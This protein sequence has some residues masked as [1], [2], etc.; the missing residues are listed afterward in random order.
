MLLD[1]P[2]DL[3]RQHAVLGQAQDEPTGAVPGAVNG[4]VKAQGVR[5]ADV[6]LFGPLMIYSAMDRKPPPWMNAAMLAIG[7]GTILYNAG[8][9]LKVQRRQQPSVD[10]L[11]MP[12]RAGYLNTKVPLPGTSPL[13]PRYVATLPRSRS[14]WG[15]K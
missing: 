15:R 13:R 4:E 12:P 11:A 9:Y 1:L 8:N 7:V 14:F 3:A 10:G 5:L 6:F 2:P